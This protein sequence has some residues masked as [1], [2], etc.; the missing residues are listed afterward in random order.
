MRIFDRVIGL[1]NLRVFHLN[2]SKKGLGSKVDRHAHIGEGELG[3]APFSFLLADARF[4]GIPGVLETEHGDD[5]V[6]L[7]RDLETLRAL[8]REATQETFVTRSAA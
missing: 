6:E 3:K 7:K 5:C 1:A 8:A 2:D 4:A